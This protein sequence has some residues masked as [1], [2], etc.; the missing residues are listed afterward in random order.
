MLDADE[1]YM[2]TTNIDDIHTMNIEEYLK[3]NQYTRESIDH[4]MESLAKYKVQVKLLKIFND[5]G[6]SPKLF[7]ILMECINDNF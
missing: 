6:V 4:R 3:I 5:E 2:S 7:Y 1:E